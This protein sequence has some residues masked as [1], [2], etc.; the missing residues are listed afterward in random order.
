MQK[1]ILK[2]IFYI[3]KVYKIELNFIDKNLT[4]FEILL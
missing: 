4:S 2:F 1:V 3:A